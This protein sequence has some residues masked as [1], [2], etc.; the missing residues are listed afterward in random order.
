MRRIDYF[1]LF[2]KGKEEFIQ[3]FGKNDLLLELEAIEKMGSSASEIIARGYHIKLSALFNKEAKDKLLSNDDTK[4]KMAVVWGMLIDK[5]ARFLVLFKE[6]HDKNSSVIIESINIIKHSRKND[7]NQTVL[8]V[9]EKSFCD[10]CEATNEVVKMM[11]APYSPI[12]SMIHAFFKDHC[13]LQNETLGD[14]NLVSDPM[15]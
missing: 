4:M 6:G 9:L 3:A 11:P 2:D 13:L 12:A 10:L 5:N 7:D 8:R 14:L 1:L 15:A